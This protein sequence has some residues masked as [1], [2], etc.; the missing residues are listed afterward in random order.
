MI[1]EWRWRAFYTLKVQMSGFHNATDKINW[2]YASLPSLPVTP[3]LLWGCLLS[4]Y[5]LPSTQVHCIQPTLSFPWEPLRPIRKWSSWGQQATEFKELPSRSPRLSDRLWDQIWVTWSLGSMFW[6]TT[7][8]GMHMKKIIQRICSSI[9]LSTIYKRHLVIKSE[10]ISPAQVCLGVP[11][12][13][14]PPKGPETSL[15]SHS[16]LWKV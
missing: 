11:H 5:C 7:L 14:P 13:D 1:G 16:E 4:T 12:I 10:S 6:H 3:F 8:F 9:L 15:L 2:H